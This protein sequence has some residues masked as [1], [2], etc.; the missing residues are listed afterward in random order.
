MNQLNILQYE[1]SE[2]TVYYLATMNHIR[3]QKEIR[4]RKFD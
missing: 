2:Q 3:A 4:N 1:Y